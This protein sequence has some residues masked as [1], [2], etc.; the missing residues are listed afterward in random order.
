MCDVRKEERNARNPCARRRGGR[1]AAS[2]P[3][4]C[5]AA[6][7]VECVMNSGAAQHIYDV[8]PFSTM[9]ETMR[10][11]RSMCVYNVTRASPNLLMISYHIKLGPNHAHTQQKRLRQPSMAAARPATAARSGLR[12]PS[13]RR[14]RPRCAT[15]RARPTGAPD[16]RARAAKLCAKHAS[17]IDVRSHIANVWSAIAGVQS[18]VNRAVTRVES[19]GKPFKT[20]AKQK[21][22][23]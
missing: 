6:P 17:L 15:S 20:S 11:R 13:P 22:H 7:R 9:S 14:R 21:N 12:P 10:I 18:L 2:L 1:R 5:S 4:S 23:T 19:F 8:S 16:P 3:S